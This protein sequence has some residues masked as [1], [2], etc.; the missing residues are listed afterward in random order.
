M[1]EIEGIECLKSVWIALESEGD[2]LFGECLDNV[3]E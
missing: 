2:G 1:F 3:Q